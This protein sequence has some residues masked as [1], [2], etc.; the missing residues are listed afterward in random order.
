MTYTY[1]RNR[2]LELLKRSQYFKNQGKSFYREST[3]E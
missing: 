1:N 2:H 3:D